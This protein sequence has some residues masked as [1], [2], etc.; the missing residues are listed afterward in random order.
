MRCGD[1]GGCER[2]ATHRYIAHD[3]TTGRRVVVT[4]VCAVHARWERKMMAHLGQRRFGPDAPPI[5]QRVVTH[6]HLLRAVA[7]ATSD[8]ERDRA[9][10]DAWRLPTTQPKETR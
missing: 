1:L 2:E 5:V 4:D 9:E 3:T 10:R 8:A 7:S 6:A